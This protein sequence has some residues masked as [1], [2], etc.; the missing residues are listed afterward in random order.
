MKYLKQN[1]N[2]MNKNK[3]IV[4]YIAISLFLI[5]II[6]INALP[7]PTG[8]YGY[9]KGPHDKE[10]NITILVYEKD[11]NNLLQ[12]EN[13]ILSVGKN[14]FALAVTTDIIPYI[15]IQIIVISEDKYYYATANKTNIIPGNQEEINITLIDSSPPK[16]NEDDKDSSN[17]DS[18]TDGGGS[19]GGG[20]AP[21]IIPDDE[22]DNER[23]T[24]PPGVD[25]DEF[26]GEYIEEIYERAEDEFK[27]KTKLDEIEPDNRTTVSFNDC[28]IPILILFCSR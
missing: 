2:I 26:L 27:E 5:S 25:G 15:D 28:R 13:Q 18:P 4:M 1:N 23:N 17:I 21:P 20:G 22:L 24:M 7:I 16:E 10:L 11:T 9:I 14:R 6:S 12:Y 8:I 3:Y 19:G